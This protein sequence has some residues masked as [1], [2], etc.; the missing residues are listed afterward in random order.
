MYLSLLEKHIKNGILHLHLPDG[1]EYSFGSGGTEAHWYIQDEAAI[2]RI[3]RDWEFELGETYIQGCWNAGNAGLRNLLNVLRANFRVYRM[4][5]GLRRLGTMLQEWNRVSRSYHNVSHHYDVPEHVFRQFL[6]QEMFY[7]CAY[8]PSDELSLDEAQQAKARHIARKLQIRPGDHILDIGCGWGSLAFH[9]AS[10][11]DC[12]ITGITLS[13]EQLAVARSEAEKR[14]VTNVNFELADYREHRGNYDRIVSVGMFEHVGRPFYDNYFQQVR[15]MLKPDGIA[16]IHTIGR[17]GPPGVTNPWIRKYIFPG[18]ST[19]ALSEITASVE[20]TG[21]RVTDVEVW[22]LHYA[23][24]LRRWYE[25]FQQNREDI[26]STMSEEFCRMWEFYLAACESAFRHS[27][28]VVYQVQL[29]RE[30]NSVPLTRDYIYR[31]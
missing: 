5:S 14:G 16:L 19:P 2:R 28:L 1:R 24:T 31:E 22:R 9:L 6:D 29:A 18:G 12:Q 26:R 3:A 7:S 30:I 4:N 11:S 25:R 21:L 8:F 13:R 20:N 10:Q 15:N 27:D 17:S 23:Q